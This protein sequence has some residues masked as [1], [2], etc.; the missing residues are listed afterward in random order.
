LLCVL[1]AIALAAGIPLLAR[2][3][4]GRS[5]AEAEAYDDVYYI[6]LLTGRDAN[7]ALRKA[8]YR[9][10]LLMNELGMTRS[11]ATALAV[12]SVIWGAGNLCS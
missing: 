2:T 9:T 7:A 1:L 12:R 11:E 10:D 3:A 5:A 6:A 4:F 8:H